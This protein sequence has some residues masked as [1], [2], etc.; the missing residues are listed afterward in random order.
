MTKKIF[1]IAGEPSGDALGAS[2]MEAL[3][4]QS[5]EPIEF[6]GIGGDLM[7]EQ[8]LDSLLP[9]EELCVMGLVEVLTHL[10]RLLR[11]I[12]GVVEEVEKAN[13]DVLITI[14]LPDFNFQVASRLKKRG[15][16]KAKRIHYV[17]PS[18]WAWR[19]KRAQKIS[20]FLDGLICLLPFEPPYFKKYKLPTKFAG[21]PLS[22]KNLEDIDGAAFR[23]SHDIDENAIVVGLLLGSRESEL[24]KHG[25]AFR[26]TMRVLFKHYPELILVVP[27]L[28]NLEFQVREILAGT[29]TNAMI[30]TDAN[31]K[32]EAFAAC[33]AALAVSGTV[34]LELA[35]MGVPHIIGY[36]MHPLT[37]VIARLMVKTK[38]GHLA[39]ILLEDEVV[40]EYLQG[41]CSPINLSIGLLRLLKS[42]QARGEQREAFT[43]LKDY[44]RGEQDA[45]PSE[46]AAKFVFDVLND[47][48]TPES[49]E[50][51]KPI[52]VKREKT[53]VMVEDAQESQQ[54][55]DVA[56]SSSDEA[57]ELQEV[58]GVSLPAL[59]AQGKARFE[60]LKSRF[61]KSPKN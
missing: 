46:K 23:K 39:N 56:A 4:A 41:R 35:Y 3:K 14:D 43:V 24:K 28:P 18:V 37:Y 53:S 12:N 6:I 57:A 50:V 13:P 22:Q 51:A 40:P 54:A 47:T 52:W 30:I 58:E 5:P 31:K 48:Y 8:G 42:E 20:A 59:I 17:A 10:P 55:Q 19:G 11:L 44:M 2:L 32:Y 16:C 29:R 45:S 61:V 15:T 25:P 36:K 34:G 7:A 33:N 38:Y 26:E 49:S 27:T 1:L 60:E 21:H 9:M